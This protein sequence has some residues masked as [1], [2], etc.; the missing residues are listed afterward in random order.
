MIIRTSF[1]RTNYSKISFMVLVCMLSSANQLKAQDSVIVDE[2]IEIIVPTFR[3]RLQDS[4]FFINGS[5]QTPYM[6][7]VPMIPENT[8]PENF[9]DNGEL[10]VLTEGYSFGIGM[11][12][13][14]NKIFEA[15]FLVDYYYNAVPVTQSGERSMGPWVLE[16]TGTSM[17]TTLFEKDHNRV[18][19]TLVIRATARLKWPL[20][21]VKL[22]GGLAGG[23]YSST[24]R[25]T[26]RDKTSAINSTSRNQLGLSYQAG[27]DLMIKNKLEKD[28]LS[29]TLFAD[30]ASPRM[31][32]KMLDAIE[33]GWMFEYPGGNKVISP[34]RIGIAFNVH[35][36]EKKEAR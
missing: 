35:L 31:E 26:D 22:W 9:T 8:P 1:I 10:H 27:M 21:P 2:G 20:G 14:H 33:T 17:Y 32:E 24:V 25:F 16:Q 36:T 23:T 19:E 30:F 5:W 29:V 34:V 4:Y 3:E 15:G 13:I 28:I 7:T 12:K 18:S 11:L 6:V